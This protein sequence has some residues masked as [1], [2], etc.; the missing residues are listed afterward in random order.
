MSNF[1]L[2]CAG[3]LVRYPVN[4]TVVYRK[5]RCCGKQECY[6]EIDRK[7]THFNYKKQQKKI[8]AG[9]FRHGVDPVLREYIRM[10]DKLV[11]QKCQTSLDANVLQVHHIVPV[12]NGGTDDKSN[13][14]LLCHKCHTEVHQ[15][16]YEYYV[17]EFTKYASIAESVTQ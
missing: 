6:D 5:K 1:K 10:R 7:V 15:Y 9:K 16:G 13:L 4:N 17:D 3:C 14:I 2:I 8:K 12:S 11:C